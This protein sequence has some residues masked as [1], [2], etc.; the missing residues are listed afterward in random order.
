M[1]QKEYKEI[2]NH[3][4]IFCTENLTRIVD[5]R[6][7]F[8]SEMSAKIC[9]STFQVK[10]SVYTI[11][12]WHGCIWENKR[13]NSSFS[14][15]CRKNNNLPLYLFSFCHFLLLVNSSSQFFSH[16]LFLVWRSHENWFDFQDDSKF[17]HN[18]FNVYF[19]RICNFA[20]RVVSKSSFVLQDFKMISFFY[21]MHCEH[22]WFQK[23]PFK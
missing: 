21:T 14:T 13:F 18:K 8:T 10:I 4:R 5:L 20:R 3:F 2:N 1:F 23:R 17:S 16:I 6:S 12:F 7:F 9:N 22:F 19:S 15:L 11:I